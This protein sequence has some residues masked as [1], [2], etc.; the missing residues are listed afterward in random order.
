MYVDKKLSGVEAVQ[1]LSRLNRTYPGK[2]K[3]FVLD[4]FNKPEEVKEA[5]DP[6][7]KTA[8]LS[9]VSDP[10]MIFELQIKLDANSIYT[11]KEVDDFALAFFDPKG[12]QKAMSSAVKPATDRFKTRYK[13]A[14][15]AIKSAKESL[16]FAKESQDESL[17]HNAEMD[18]KGAKQDKDELDLFKKDLN[19]FSKMY[20]FL[21]QI[22]DYGDEELEK[23]NAYAKG[24]LPNLVV[25]EYEPPI[26]LSDVAMTH[27]SLKNKKTHKIDLKGNEIRGI[28]EG[29]SGTARD[30][31]SDTIAH[32]V[33]KMNDLFAGELSDD[34]KVNYAKTITDK[35]M[36][37]QSAITQF[38]TNSREQ[39]MLGD[40]PA[41]MTDAIIDSM[42]V[43]QNMA[44]QV[45]SDERV[46]VG[47]ANLVLDM[48]YKQINQRPSL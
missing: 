33:E 32:I 22:V 11:T 45:L 34:D 26:D 3:T 1:T 14:V 16:D 42:D 48:I 29:G 6:Y 39:A 20:D 24:L 10:Q 9:D 5:F 38:T 15:Q 21:S 8:N 47:F 36:E 27:F 40:F 19:T 4:F 44:T 12:T 30:P 7:Y 13:N 35:V 25:G 28:G 23:L 2:N 17:I 37:N 18:M 31:E 41:L 43:H 46:K